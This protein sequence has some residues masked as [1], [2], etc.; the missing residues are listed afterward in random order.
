[1]LR[2]TKQTTLD[3]EPL[4]KLPER[5]QVLQAA[6]FSPGEAEFYRKLEKEAAEKMQASVLLFKLKG[7]FSLFACP[8]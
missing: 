1:M 7:C 8:A 3:G 2:R 5:R 4:V 6:A